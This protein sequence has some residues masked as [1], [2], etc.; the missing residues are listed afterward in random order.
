MNLFAIRDLVCA[1]DLCIPGVKR[2]ARS[3]SATQL[4]EDVSLPMN[5][6]ALEA[7][8]LLSVSMSD[9][10]WTV[11]R[12]EADSRVIYV[13]SSAGNDNNDGLSA[14]AA[15]KTLAKAKSLVRDGSADQILLKRGDVWYEGF[16][17]WT[18]SGRSADAPLLIS[19]YGNGAR[20][21]LRTGGESA[22]TTSAS[23]KVSYVAIIGLELHAHTRDPNFG[24]SYSTGGNAGI[25]WYA[26][27]ESL[28]IEDVRVSYYR[29]NIVIQ[30]RDGFDD[31]TLR[32]SQVIGAYSTSSHSQGLFVKNVHGVELDG[33]L[34]DH[35]GWNAKI[36]GAEAT[37]FNHNVYIQVDSTGLVARNNTFSRASSHGLQARRGG[38][39]ENNLF[40]ANPIGMTYGAVYGGAVGK[41][42]LPK[43]GV[44]GRIVNNVFL[45]GGDISSSLPRGVGI[46][47]G[48]IRTVVVKD[49]LFLRDAT[50]KNTGSA[51]KLSGDVEAGVNNTTIT[52]NVIYNWKN[53]IRSTGEGKFRNIVIENNTIYADISTELVRF[54][55]D[56]TGA[57]TFR[58]NE[59]HSRAS[60]WFRAGSR[61]DLSEWKRKTGDNSVA[62]ANPKFAD[63][64]RSITSL[65]KLL[66][67]GN[68]DGYL[69]AVGNMHRLSWKVSHTAESAVAYF[70]DGF[71]GKGNTPNPNPTPTPVVSVS[72]NG[73]AA[74]QNRKAA[75]FIL[76]RTGDLSDSL[77]VKYVLGGTA[78][79]GVD[80]TELLGQVTFAAGQATAV[81]R[82]VPI[83]D[84]EVEG[85]ETVVF[86][87]SNGNGYELGDRTA[88]I[89]IADNDKAPEPDPEPT[90]GRLTFLDSSGNQTNRQLGMATT[91]V[92]ERSYRGTFSLVN[93]SDGDVTISNFKLAGSH[94]QD[95]EYRV[96]DANGNEVTGSTFVVKAGETFTIEVTFVPTKDG[97]RSASFVFTTDSANAADR[98]VSLNMAGMGVGKVSEP[99]PEPVL[100]QLE[101]ADSSGNSTN[102]QLGL[103]NTRVGQNSSA[104]TFTLTNNG[105][106][107]LQVNNFAIGGDHPQ[108]FSYRILDA[109]G[110]EI[111]GDSFTVEAGSYVTIEVVFAPTANGSRLGEFNFTTNDPNEAKVRL[112]FAGLGHSAVTPK[113]KV[114]DSS[115][116]PDN[117]QLGL[118]N[119]RVG[120][121]SH[122]GS[123]TLSNTGDVALTVRDLILTGDHAN[124]FTYEILDARGNRIDASTFEIAAG[125]RVTILTTVSPK[126][127]GTRLGAFTFKVDG[128]DNAFTLGVAALGLA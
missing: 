82:V 4:L 53:G 109:N 67:N 112:T 39:I 19:S 103:P 102:R 86:T 14:N 101:V 55:E 7:R 41:D 85:D 121:T 35:N 28:L 30:S 12:P 5:L 128:L 122:A 49:N 96:L 93:D 24:S 40:I 105:D 10:G 26:S 99:D 124:E 47:L 59:Y 70:H 89:T 74:E 11:V 116:N 61:M 72:R 66:G 98:N 16:G 29:D 8:V 123:Y 92:G 107:E 127:A 33:N 20:P 46:E 27:G 17:S 90:P 95:F 23:A 54:S 51:I 88:T 110:K 119:T 31:F 77:T 87:L 71:T 114:T 32:R 76:T 43:N 106:G 56:I 9:D 111:K 64:S 48:N 50:D 120:R 100:P 36:K 104:G 94:P 125:E 18:K 62:N 6:E 42:M 73:N 37:I 97:S 52:N 13:S 115:G 58:N 22:I 57:F 75:E 80:Y 60:D 21:I 63:E 78:T 81:V 34:F 91:N 126:A 68:L 3:E 44:D 108:D 79:N 69:S 83:D 1:S 2:Q 25:R 113:I 117:H 45:D 118:A 38:I 84:K 65:A 15:V